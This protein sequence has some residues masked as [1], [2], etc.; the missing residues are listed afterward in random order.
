MHL[1]TF[2]SKR[3]K[4]LF[5]SPPLPVTQGEKLM[6]RLNVPVKPLKSQ[7]KAVTPQQWKFVQELVSEDGRVTLKEAAI[8]AGYSEKNASWE[9]GITLKWLPRSK[10]TDTS[11]L[12][13]TARTLSGTCVTCR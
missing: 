8:R 12:R 9:S 7:P 4:E 13:S 3:T 10:N 1:E 2:L 5:N 6:E 11:L